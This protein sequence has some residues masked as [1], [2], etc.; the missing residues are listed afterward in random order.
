MSES[1]ISQQL[2]EVFC[3]Y[4]ECYA[5][6]RQLKT[7]LATKMSDGFFEMA[8]ARQRSMS[9]N[10]GEHNYANRIFS[11]SLVLH[12]DDKAPEHEAFR[13]DLGSAVEDN[14]TESGDA[15]EVQLRRRRVFTKL[16]QQTI[17]AVNQE[18]PPDGDEDHNHSLP[19]LLPKPSTDSSA[20][21]SRQKAKYRDDPVNWFGV[22]APAPL[23]Q[24]QNKFKDV[25]AHAVEISNLHRQLVGLE[26]EYRELL[27]HKTN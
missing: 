18:S 4:F 2:D 5:Q 12:S 25:V 9:S 24:A 16:S 21:I 1:Q 10:F 7:L 27:E 6:I 22:L 3:K 15:D 11:P 26:K 19:E 20:P 13:W 8:K 14:K 17:S 23:R